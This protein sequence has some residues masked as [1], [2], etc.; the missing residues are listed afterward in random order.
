MITVLHVIWHEDS[1]IKDF[2]V[3]FKQKT[4]NEKMKK[5][6]PSN[7]CMHSYVFWPSY[8]AYLLLKFSVVMIILFKSFP[9]NKLNPQI[10]HAEKQTKQR[11]NISIFLVSTFNGHVLLNISIF[12][13]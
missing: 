9:Q 11:S 3:I 12:L 4:L 10:L 5:K 13:V 6:Q 7:N 8:R 1:D 2:S